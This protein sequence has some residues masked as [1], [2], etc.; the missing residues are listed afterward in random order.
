MVSS[1]AM[2][3]FFNFGKSSGEKPALAEKIFA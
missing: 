3:S 2:A 1:E